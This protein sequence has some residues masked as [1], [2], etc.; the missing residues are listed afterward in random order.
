MVKRGEKKDGDTFFFFFFYGNCIFKIQ[1]D[2][3]RK[4]GDAGAINVI[5]SGMKAHIESVDVCKFGCGA[6]RNITDDNGKYV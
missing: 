3:Q 2:S 5:L 6:L 4:A 1:A